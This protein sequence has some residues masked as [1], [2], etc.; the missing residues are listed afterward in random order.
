M[1]ATRRRP[2]LWIG[3]ALFSHAT[4][5]SLVAVLDPTVGAATSVIHWQQ[6]APMVGAVAALAFGPRMALG[7]GTLLA[8]V[9]SLAAAIRPSAQL[10]SVSLGLLGHGVLLSCSVG[11]LAAHW[12]H[13]EARAR[14]IS[15]LAVWMGMTAWSLGSAGTWQPSTLQ[16]VVLGAVTTALG[17]LAALVPP[18]P[19]T[20]A[21]AH[22]PPPGALARS[23]LITVGLLSPVVAGTAFRE[24][25]ELGRLSPA[26]A[27]REL[28]LGTA[29]ELIAL[30]VALGFVLAHPRPDPRRLAAVS[31]VTVGASLLFSP[32]LLGI[33]ADP[34]LLVLQMV[35]NLA[36]GWGIVL[37]PVMLSWIL[38]GLSARSCCALA[39]MVLSGVGIVRWAAPHVAQAAMDAT[40]A[41]RA[42]VVFLA[43]VASV[44]AGTCGLWLGVST[45]QS[46]WRYVLARR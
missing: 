2:V 10:V 38:A 42:T 17:A 39:G 26:S 46:G 34:A 43:L 19:R 13:G 1:V 25:V 18:A 27:V 36:E 15:L 11:A 29:A 35:T 3:L 12:Q 40:H 4:V 22:D 37:V 33:H 32:A 45:R 23:A 31:W 16:V 5:S 14:Q 9:G 7:V 21:E 6:T 30:L 28:G 20:P 8:L 41:P 24:L 44:L